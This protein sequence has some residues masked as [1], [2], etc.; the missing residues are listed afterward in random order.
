MQTQTSIK[1]PYVILGSAIGGVA[2]YLFMTQSGRKVRQQIMSGQ[3]I[4]DARRFIEKKGSAITGQ[5]RNVLDKAKESISAGQH[6]YDEAEQSYRAQFQKI[7]GKNNEIASNVHKTV[8]N[9]NRTAV[10]VEQTVLDPL[11]EAGALFRGISRGVR[12]FF[13]N[14]RGP[15][16]H[17]PNRSRFSHDEH[18]TGSRGY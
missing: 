9:W 8:D 6:A 17:E 18:T 12:T 14:S 3:K 7:Q 5:V 16:L 2:G 4:E 10:T 1:V 15:H 11:Y 13:G